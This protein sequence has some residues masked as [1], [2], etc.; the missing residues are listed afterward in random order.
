[1]P[2]FIERIDDIR[3]AQGFLTV[4]HTLQLCEQGVTI[5]DLFSTLISDRAV[6]SPGAFFW[7]NVTITVGEGGQVSIGPGTV[8]HSGVRIDAISGSVRIGAGGD[9]G[10]EGGFT[11]ITAGSDDV[12]N[13]GD[14]VR[15][16]GGGLIAFRADIG[17]GAQVLG[18]IRVQNCRLGGGGSF[19]EPDPDRRGAVLKGCGVAREL[20]VPT[21]MVIQAFGIFAEA[22]VRW[23][24]H[25]HPKAADGS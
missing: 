8:L 19:R 12:V 22:P 11:L 21:G 4:E 6:L 14:G 24:S 5:M 9:I 16:N 13:I 25:F 7:P 10:Q 2:D 20:D 23:Q 15:L 1:M 17:D 3:K 18:A